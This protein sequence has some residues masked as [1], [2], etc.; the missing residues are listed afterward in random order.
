[1]RRVRCC[2]IPRKPCV[3]LKIKEISQYCCKLTVGPIILRAE[4]AT[5]TVISG[6]W[7]GFSGLY[8][9]FVMRYAIKLI[10]REIQDT[11]SVGTEWIGVSCID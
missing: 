7:I 11:R 6:D 5:R 3:Y 9:G 2:S 10:C 8:G 1:M 4:S